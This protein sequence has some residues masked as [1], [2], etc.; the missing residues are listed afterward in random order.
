MGCLGARPRPPQAQSLSD[1]S[2]SIMYIF[3]GDWPFSCGLW[4]FTKYD[5]PVSNR[6]P[7]CLPPQNNKMAPQVSR[8]PCES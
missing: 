4:S 6:Q 1:R 7:I 2:Q 8:I 5:V 3:T